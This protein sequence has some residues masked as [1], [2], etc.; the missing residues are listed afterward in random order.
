MPSALFQKAAG[1]L[2]QRKYA[3][4]VETTEYRLEDDETTLMGKEQER[5]AAFGAAEAAEVAPG[6][7]EEIPLNEGELLLSS[8]ESHAQAAHQ[9]S[10]AAASRPRMSFGACLHL[11]RAAANTTTAG[12]GLPTAFSDRKAILARLARSARHAAAVQQKQQKQ[13][14][15]QTSD[16]PKPVKVSWLCWFTVQCYTAPA[17]ILCE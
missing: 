1:R 17:A 6:T 7:L 12:A 14:Q 13:Q 8:N 4:I 11:N 10:K 9:A 3:P 15:Q 16:Q 5:A 2:L